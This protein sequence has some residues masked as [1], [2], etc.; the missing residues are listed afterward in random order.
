M[1]HPQGRRMTAQQMLEGALESFERWERLRDPQALSTSCQLWSALVEALPP[2]SPYRPSCLTEL[3][4]SL[5]GWSQLTGDRAALDQAVE[6]SAT[7]VREGEALGD[8]FLDELLSNLA[9]AH[10]ERFRTSRRLPDLEA[11]I[12]AGRRSIA[13]TPDG[14]E[15]RPARRNN[16]SQMLMQ[17]YERTGDPAHREEALYATREAVAD[18]PPGHPSAAITRFHLA[19]L[20][21]ETHRQTRVS[22]V[23]DESIDMA[24]SAVAL[25]EPSDPLRAAALGGL[26][27]GLFHRV[28]VSEKEGTEISADVEELIESA[29]HAIEQGDPSDPERASSLLC[30]AGGLHR[31]GELTDDRADL[32]QA[33]DLYES[34]LAEY[35]E[36]DQRTS[37]QEDLAVCLMHRHQRTNDARDLRAAV[38]LTRCAARS[39]PESSPV[40]PRVLL[41]QATALYLLYD[42]HTAEA[43]DLDEAAEAARRGI[44]LSVEDSDAIALLRS[45]LSEILR[46]RFEDRGDASDLEAA[47]AAVLRAERDT[48]AGAAH[49]PLIL[50][51]VAGVLRV[52]A[53]HTG[54][55][56]DFTAAVDFAR[57]SVAGA[58]PGLLDKALAL[59]GLGN[60]LQARYENGGALDDLHGAIDAKRAATE[61]PGL[62]VAQRALCLSGLGYSLLT[63]FRHTGDVADLTAAIDVCTEAVRTV[64]ADHPH[65]D[66]YLANLSLALADSYHRHERRHDLDRAVMT[67]RLAVE[68]TPRGSH[69]RP[70][71]LNNLAIVTLD[72]FSESND[73]DDLEAAITAMREAID[74]ASDDHPDQVKFRS[75][76]SNMLYRRYRLLG[77]E[78]DLGEALRAG[79]LAVEQCPA[80]HESRG[81][82][83]LFLG[84][85]LDDAGL[86][87]E[88]VDAF[89]E[90]AQLP[91]GRLIVRLQAA[92]EWGAVAADDGR[93]REAQRGYEYAIELLPQAAWHGL[94]RAD[95]EHF[96][97]MANG[98]ASDAAA[99]AIERGD[100]TRAVELLEQGRG[101]LLAQAFDARTDLDELR[102]LDGDLARAMDGVRRR[103]D[104]VGAAGA[105]REARDV[106]ARQA[107][108]ESQ[109]RREAAA[110]WDRLLDRARALVPDFLRPRP[111][112][113]LR[114][115]ARNGPVA[116]VNVA[117]YRCDALLVTVDAPESPLLVRLERI[118]RPVVNARARELITTIRDPDATTPQERN[119]TLRSILA[120]LWNDIA[121]PV[122]TKLAWP[123]KPAEGQEPRLWWCPTGALTLLPLHAAGIYPAP[124]DRRPCEDAPTP[125]SSNNL[126]DRAVCSYAP[127]LRAL[128][129]AISRP[130]SKSTT[131]LG[132]AVPNAPGMSELRHAEAEIGSLREEFPTMTAILGP[133]ANRDTILEL[134]QS[135]SW[136]H[137][138]GHGSQYSLA[139]GALHC[140]DAMI[141]LRDLTALRLTAA[142]LA[143]LSA[144][145]TAS[146]VARLADEFA[147]LAGGLHIAGFRHVIATQWSISDL[148]APQVARDFYRALQGAPQTA[149]E[150]LQAAFAL[151]RAVRRLRSAR[152]DAPVLWASYLHTGP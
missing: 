146:G 104:G 82:C 56:A 25:S 87:T 33:I 132:I 137:F 143:F 99:V 144:C 108:L 113:R 90:A 32:D 92:R 123:A 13:A 69:R 130:T 1:A 93:W 148:R 64:Q 37:T 28:L 142:E 74:A 11:G 57:E 94:E 46:C 80:D 134:L 36:H 111:F 150:I 70:M 27:E 14:H 48:P 52:R 44:Y 126:L 83:L 9:L 135:H 54:N 138:A 118:S 19:E 72:R 22:T 5:R 89:R 53:Q 68:A 38:D 133:Q 10:W 112:D 17:R 147:H 102:A 140:T 63:R 124:D 145:E 7:A 103:L 78:R 42:E 101:V 122:L 95:R 58:C 2:G 86:V 29:R 119:N 120:W 106:S 21:R 97:S 127:T 67:A 51:A 41:V 77:Q 65:Q 129:D 115:A 71:N 40:L 16:L 128:L 49:R 59:N 141:I 91:T 15:R 66:R 81:G 34:F 6:V 98:L 31:R 109:R 139:G 50:H 8:E 149:D 84:E 60:A 107:A 75:N 79:R 4:R 88:A 62:S 43:T 100:L 45:T 55:R 30:L 151:H 73:L 61:A 117:R 23:L 121:D 110:E 85:A 96:L 152:P 39:L 35:P 105:D 116:I 47:A 76:L 3:G 131:L 114:E 26:A 18:T 125:T 24:R 12:A 136:L 20:L